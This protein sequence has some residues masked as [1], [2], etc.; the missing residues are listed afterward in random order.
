MLT[1]FCSVIVLLSVI[2]PAAQ[3]QTDA[4]GLPKADPPATNPWT[5]TDHNTSDDQFQFAIVADRTG[6]RRPGVFAEAVGKLNLLQPEFVMSVGDLIDG[7]T[8]DPAEIDAQWR[9]FEQIVAALE[10]PFCHVPGNHD[11]SNEVMAAEWT[12]RH[13][14]PYHHFVYKDVLFLVLNTQDPPSGGISDQQV[15][16]VEQALEANPDVR[17][18]LVFMHQ[19]FWA[20]A[21]ESKQDWLAVEELLRGRNY[22]VFAGHWH[23]YTLY[24]RNGMKYHMLATT[25]GGNPMHGAE[26]GCFD[27]IVWVTMTDQGPRVANLDLA[28]ILN[29][30][31]MTEETWALMKAYE[32]KAQPIGGAALR[33]GPAEAT[34]QLANTS[35]YPLH[36]EA[37]FS[38]HPDVTIE[39]AVF[40]STVEPN[41]EQELPIKVSV[42][43][44]VHPANLGSATLKATLTFDIPDREN[45]VIERTDALHF[46][47]RL[48]CT[49]RTEP[50]T[51]D[52]RLD[53]WDE[54]PIVMRYPAQIF[55]KINEWRGPED[56]H[57]RMTVA[58]DDDFVYIAVRTFDDNAFIS[59]ARPLWKQDAVEFRLSAGPEPEN[60]ER[61]EYVKE[62][63]IIVLAAGETPDESQVYTNYQ[64]PQGLQAKCVKTDNGQT[65]EIA[66][67]VSW[68]N[69]RSGGQ[70]S[71]FRLN[72]S[73]NDCDGLDETPQNIWWK[74]DWRYRS[75]GH[76]ADLSTFV[77][78]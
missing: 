8:E 76:L 9:E 47:G 26:C 56:S 62:Q 43:D 66:V 31:V 45:V 61:P 70:W 29:D 12:K 3:A 48:S 10:M 7:Y 77:R 41:S 74:P 71:C 64:V 27:Q 18:T 24:E 30:D 2:I 72:V 42:A 67:P 55:P 50:V 37:Y 49:K 78:E 22:S 6:G 51:V 35:D 46:G 14:R 4:P 59:P 38:P 65:M 53:E 69:E 28:G 34:I 5:N 75:Q 40:E 17:W 60:G 13:G 54:L 36:V 11:I 57:F 23:R 20:Y 52:G 33:N 25:G 44:F 15:Q 68:L 58:H 73:L 39:P 32:I 1:R 16:Y 21:N 19:P 63:F